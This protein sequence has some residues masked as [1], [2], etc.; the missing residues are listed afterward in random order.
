MGHEHPVTG[1]EEEHEPLLDQVRKDVDPR[2]EEEQP[3]VEEA[4]AAAADG[5]AVVGLHLAAH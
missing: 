2:V 5:R 3:D 4:T 1:E